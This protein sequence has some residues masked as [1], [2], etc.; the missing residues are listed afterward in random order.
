MN[1]KTPGFSVNKKDLILILAA[2]LMIYSALRI[3]N[4][5]PSPTITVENEFEGADRSEE[6][7]DVVDLYEKRFIARQTDAPRREDPHTFKPDNLPVIRPS[8]AFSSDLPR[9]LAEIGKGKDLS[10][11]HDASEVLMSDDMEL[12]IH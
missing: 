11:D 4:I 3:A 12:V 5:S 7:Y 1:N 2:L 10:T 8:S 9:I 6:E